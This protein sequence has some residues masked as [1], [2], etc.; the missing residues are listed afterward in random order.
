MPEIQRDAFITKAPARLGVVL[1]DAAHYPRSLG[2]DVEHCELGGL[3]SWDT[4]PQGFMD[5]P[6]TWP[7]PTSF[8]VADGAGPEATLRGDVEAL[9]ALAVAARR[10]EASCDVITTSC[11]F[12]WAGWPLVKE[13]VRTPCILSA[14]D[15]LELAA[16]M[17][18]KPVGVLSYS[19]EDA[20]RLL[21]SRPDYDRLRILGFN[22][23]PAWQA[24]GPYDFF[25]STEWSVE[26]LRL[27]F[28]HRCAAELDGGVL[29]GVGSIV[30]ECTAMPPFRSALRE[31][32][33][34]P[35][36]DVVSIVNAVLR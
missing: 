34:V 20:R 17:S 19:S 15:S 28:L 23:L 35:I 4:L 5:H 8:T 33:S 22:D 31:L 3:P 18:S 10:L 11:G 30:F 32:T 21:Q 29:E 27:E 14:L 36:L 24:I 2:R 26:S 13:E 7:F 12:F 9:S 16:Q 6:G 25:Y 1:M